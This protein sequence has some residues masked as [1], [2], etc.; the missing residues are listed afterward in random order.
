MSEDN[1]LRPHIIRVLPAVNKR[2]RAYAERQG[3]APNVAAEDLMNGA[4]GEIAALDQALVA[5]RAD[6]ESARE[7]TR[8][9]DAEIERLTRELAEVR[10][11]A[12]AEVDRVNDAYTAA[13]RLAD[14]R[15]A[16][17]ANLRLAEGGRLAQLD[18]A[19]AEIDRLGGALQAERAAWCE[20]SGA[21]SPTHLAA[22]LETK[23]AADRLAERV[24]TIAAALPA[25]FEAK[26]AERAP[27]WKGT[28]DELRARVITLGFSR[29]DALATDAAKRAAERGR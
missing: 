19:N 22:A 23:G 16:E 10:D 17:A 3:V 15:E 18:M 12:R 1:R 6:L 28:A 25:D 8:R 21:E 13:L 4:A 9:A 27:G 7:A 24:E 14:K 2:V 29:Y 5:L 20:A 26:I 11:A